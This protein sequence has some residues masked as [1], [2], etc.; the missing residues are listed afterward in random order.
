MD[1]QQAIKKPFLDLKKL[2][3][4]IVLNI[5]PIVNF[6]AM[7]YVLETA[8]LTLSKKNNLPEWKDWKD[9]FIHGVLAT[10][11]SFIYMI[12]ALV[13]A[14]AA[15]G[16]GVLKGWITGSVISGV[17]TGA[18]M[19]ITALI[20][21]LLATYIAPM[22]TLLY[23]KKW[24]FADAFAFKEIFKKIIT[25]KYAVAWIVMLVISVVAIGVLS[26]IPLVG[27]EA[28]SFIAGVIGLTILAQAYNE[29]K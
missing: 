15:V 16:F 21:V 2:V 1:Y 27:S 19:L 4:G 20:L 13:V 5:I 22:S 18:P 7:G 10:I 24:K 28:G 11:I 29:I 6:F 26:I 25:P 23:V 12:P 8:K 17:E 9:L 3:I 14:V